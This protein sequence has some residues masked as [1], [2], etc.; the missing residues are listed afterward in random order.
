VLAEFERNLTSE[1]TS[2]ALRFKRARGE[3]AG[4]VPYGYR[5]GDDR[6]TLE[7]EP[8]ELAVVARIRRLRRRGLTLRAIASTLNS[9]GV[10]TR[11]GGIWAHQYVAA[12]LRTAPESAPV[13]RKAAA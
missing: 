7:P 9:A 11:R 5:V 2:A 6:T 1:R 12:I 13:A 3:R 4:N 8:S 10:P